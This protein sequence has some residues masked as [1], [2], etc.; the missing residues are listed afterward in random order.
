MLTGCPIP[1]PA[2]GAALVFLSSV[3]E[4][5]S[6]NTALTETFSTTY[7]TNEGP[8][9]DAA[10]LETSNG[11]GGPQEKQFHLGSTSHGSSVEEE[12]SAMQRALAASLT[13]GSVALGAALV[14][15][16]LVI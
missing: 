5:E 11:R 8:T 16:M 7:F 4:D 13:L 3:A 12:N 9:T 14:G 1:I 6:F 15:R 10:A 2:P